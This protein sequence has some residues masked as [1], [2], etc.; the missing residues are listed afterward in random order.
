MLMPHGTVQ[1]L[2][3]L[4]ELPRITLGEVAAERDALARQ[5]E[6]LEARLD[7][8]QKRL[9]KQRAKVRR[10]RARLDLG[11]PVVTERPALWK[12]LRS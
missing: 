2:Q 7:T 10:L 11:T 4:V 5:V 9:R 12:R 3:E 6:R 1:R 8:V